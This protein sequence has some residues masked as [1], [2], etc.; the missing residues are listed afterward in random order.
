[1]TPAVGSVNLTSG[2]GTDVYIKVVAADNT[3]LYYKISINRMAPI[4]NFANTAKR[5]QA[6]ALAG[7]Q[8][9]E[10]PES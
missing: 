4:S 5:V 9:V 3:T 6:Q 2:S 7:Q 8:P 1:M 10:Q